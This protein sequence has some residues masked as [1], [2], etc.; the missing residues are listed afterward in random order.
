MA[1]SRRTPLFAILSSSA[2]IACALLG[3]VAEAQPAKAAPTEGERLFREGREAMDRKELALACTKFAESYAKEQVVTS[4]LN[5]A[6]CEEKRGRLATSLGLWRAGLSRADDAATKSFVEGRVRALLPRVPTLVVR[7]GHVAGAAVTFDGGA[8]ATEAP[9][10]VDPGDHVLE[11]RASGV[12]PETRRVSV[13]EGKRVEVKLFESP[14]ATSAASGS[15]AP[16]GDGASA[17]AQ[18]ASRKARAARLKTTGYV[19]GG[20]GLAGLATF[21]ITGAIV[22]THHES[23]PKFTC[24]TDKR[25]NELLG[26]N[27]FALGLG[28]VGLAVGIPL[29]VVGSKEG[30]PSKAA[31]F[32]E[33]TLG[34][35]SIRGSF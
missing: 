4:L 18:E 15:A 12:E 32:V 3:P 16:A 8:I 2:W 33:P 9:V 7:L 13:E 29:V 5:E 30:A 10:P 17:A 24:T 25:P 28:V 23:C 6:D 31:L 26:A 1:S 11:A 21:G 22:L 35:A 19:F 27:A 34:G 20:L 14:L